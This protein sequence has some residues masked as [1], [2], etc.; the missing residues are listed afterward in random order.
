MLKKLSTT[1]ALTLLATAAFADDATLVQWTTVQLTKSKA[2]MCLEYDQQGNAL[3]D[4]QPVEAD[5]C[6]AIAPTTFEARQSQNG[7]VL[8]YEFTPD[9]V[10]VASELNNYGKVLYIP[11]SYCENQQ[12]Q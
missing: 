5:R 9:R 11:N 1:I 2:A 12:Q 6:R 8:C 10:V 7:G 4:G 3:N